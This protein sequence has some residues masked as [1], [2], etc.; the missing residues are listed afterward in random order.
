MNLTILN[1]HVQ[2]FI[3]DNLNLNLVEFALK[4]PVFTNVSN[5]ELIDQ[6]EAKKRCR[7]KLPTWFQTPNIYYPNRLNI[8][9]TSS[10]ITANYKASL[11]SGTS[12]I[13]L[14]GGFGVDTCAFS[15]QFKSVV[16]CEINEDLHHIVT[17]NYKV[18]Q[19]KNISTFYGDGIAYIKQ[20]EKTFDCI[21]IDPSRRHDKK[22]KVFMLSDCEPNVPK[23]LDDLFQYAPT[24]LVKTAPLLDISLGLS[25]LKHVKSIHVV[26]V[27]NEVK[28]LLWLLQ[29]NYNENTTIETINLKPQHSE[30][31][32]FYLKNESRADVNYSIPLT[33]LFEP[34]AAIMK[35]GGFKSVAKHFNLYKLHQHAHLY[36][37]D[38]LVDFP[39]RIFKIEQSLAFN[40]HNL[41]Q[42]NISKANIATR[43]FPMTV[44]V[45]RT[46][47]K[48]EDGG[49]HYMFFTT[50]EGDKK[51]II[52]GSK[53]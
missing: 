47:F 10:E 26:A 12:L 6:I 39:G 45:L 13:D 50:I 30:S 18:L 16:H 28:E 41:K 51:W 44:A 9:Q 38:E 17:H 4:K 2:Q 7:Q 25:E 11:I 14:T 21:Y 32:R 49:A 31:F 1:T 29:L 19:A 52:T 8:E 46:K 43:N 15:K 36:T 34:N 35:S 24:I 20:N 27:N 37:S 33:Y 3:N 48:I 5:A 22:G 42:L 40:K 53:I 23:H